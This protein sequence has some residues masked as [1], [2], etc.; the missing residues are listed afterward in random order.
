MTGLLDGLVQRSDNILIS[1][2]CAI[3]VYP[4]FKIFAQCATSHSHVVA[5]DQV[6]LE[7]IV[8]YLCKWNASKLNTSNKAK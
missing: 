7:Q 5:I 4:T 2:K 3:F 1:G 8:E 6:V